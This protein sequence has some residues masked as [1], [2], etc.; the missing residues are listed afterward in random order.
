MVVVP[1]VIVVTKPEA[2][3]MDA[4]PGLLLVQLPLPISLSVEVAPTQRLVVPVIGPGAVNTVSFRNTELLP[5]EL[6][7][8]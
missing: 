3:P 1:G 2:E 6:A 8:V 4:T 5:Q 7:I